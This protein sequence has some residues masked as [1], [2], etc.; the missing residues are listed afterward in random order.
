M[1]LEQV[2]NT[3]LASA[4]D[5]KLN[6]STILNEKGSPGLTKNQIAGIALA[7]VFAIKNSTL[8][9]SILSET[10]YLTDQEVS[11][12]QAAATIMAMN[13]IYY[14]FVDLNSD[15]SFGTLPVH[16]K[17]DILKNPGIEKANFELNCLAVSVINGCSTCINVHT[18]DLIKKGSS[19]VAIQACAQIAAV[20]YAAAQGIEIAAQMA[21]NSIF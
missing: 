2:K 10:T 12:A 16:L 18:Q 17:M 21:S 5:I 3:L 9:Q 14:R 4:R 15:K 13:N 1:Q 6:L 11:A 19:R 20:L 7:S 8:I